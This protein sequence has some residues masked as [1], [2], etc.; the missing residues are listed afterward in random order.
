MIFVKD[1]GSSQMGHLHLQEER[2]RAGTSHPHRQRHAGCQPGHAHPQIHWSQLWAISL[3]SGNMFVPLPSLGPPFWGPVNKC[4]HTELSELYLRSYRFTRIYWD[5][6]FLSSKRCF[7]N[8][9][10]VHSFLLPVG[11][12]YC[13]SHRFYL[14]F[15]P[16]SL[17][18]VSKIRQGVCI[19]TLVW[20]SSKNYHLSETATQL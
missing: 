18:T 3:T 16:R 8:E 17:N 4:T 19:E 10:I 1:K 11:G 15:S 2:G 14:S 9:C 6:H 20:G 5:T 12:R 13:P 7:L